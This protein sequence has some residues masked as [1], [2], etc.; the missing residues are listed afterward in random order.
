MISLTGI[1]ARETTARII[2]SPG[3]YNIV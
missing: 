3:R 1:A 2:I